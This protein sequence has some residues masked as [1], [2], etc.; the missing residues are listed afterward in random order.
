M[1]TSLRINLTVKDICKDFV[2]SELEGKGLFGWEYR[3]TIQPEYQR[4]Y[5]YADGKKDV[6]VIESILK[7]YPL[8]LLYF[9]K[10]GDDKYEVL[11]GQQRITSIGRFV[12]GQFAVKMNGMETYFS[13]LDESLKKQ[14]Q[15]YQLLV[16]ICEGDEPEIKHWFETINIA[17]VPLKPQELLNAIYSGPFVNAAKSV[18]SNSSNSNMQKWQSYISGDPKRQDILRCAL[19]WVA[20]GED[21]ISQYMSK[22]RLDTDIKNMEAY[23]NDVISWVKV[24]FGH[25][26]SE[27]KS[28]DWG[29]LYERF[30]GQSYN[31]T[32]VQ[33][34][35]SEL[36]A[37]E[38]VENKKGIFEF[39]LGGETDYKL[40][41]IRLFEKN[42][43]KTVYEK[44]TNKAKAQ[45]VSN[46]PM[47]A[48]LENT[49]RTRIYKLTEM[50]ADHV[51]AW[52]NGGKTDINN[53]QMLCVPH[54]R[55]KGNK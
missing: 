21:K 22:H 30:H 28:V 24:L 16:Y 7:G 2:Y 18:F 8:G 1:K 45:G 10:V 43:I 54:N 9:A 19:K 14:I 5:I 11:D 3:L 48:L 55:S 29:A 15:D 39:V 44:Q 20:K 52:S 26:R 35:V 49:N 46:C 12:N 31:P 4:N 33:Q 41:E 38:H 51:A 25:P 42:V 37:D 27:M 23:F 40:L 47:C 50:D 36:Y 34:R 53:C 13:G 6:A 32:K 17:G